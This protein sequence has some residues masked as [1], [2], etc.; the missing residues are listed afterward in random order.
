MILSFFPNCVREL[1][2]LRDSSSF[3]TMMDFAFKPLYGFVKLCYFIHYLFS[4]F[5]FFF[6]FFFGGGGGGGGVVLFLFIFF[7]IIFFFVYLWLR[8]S[9]ILTC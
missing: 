6:F 8:D 1:E 3:N 2:V 5:F 7:I 9:G 4:V